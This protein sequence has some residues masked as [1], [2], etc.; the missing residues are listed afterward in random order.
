MT[1][2]VSMTAPGPG[3][4]PRRATPV[5]G[6]LAR[7]DLAS[8]I[9]ALQ[10]DGRRVIG[11]T[12]ADGAVV[13]DEIDDV[14]DLPIGW[15]VR[16]APGSYR[17]EQ[18]DDER[19]FD[20]VLGPTAWK[21]YTFPSVVPISVA[22][23]TGEDGHGVEFQRATETPPRLAFLGVRACEIAA[24]LVQ[25]RVFLGGPATDEDYRARRAAACIVAV[26]CTTSADTCFCTSMGT[27]PEVTG[28]FDLALTELADGFVV[29][30]GSDLGAAIAAGLPLV[31]ADAERV[32]SAADA[33][34]TVRASIGRPVAADGLPARLLAALDS[35]RWATV[36]ER[37]L[38][39]ANCTL[40]C[41]TCFCTSVGQVSDLDGLVSTSERRWDSCFNPG[42]A[43]VAGGNF[44]PR[45]RDR[46]RQWLTHKFATWTEQF[47][48]SGCVGCGRCITWCPVGIDVRAELLA[49]A[50]PTADPSAAKAN[51][52]PQ[53][54]PVATPIAVATAAP[55]ATRHAPPVAT[56][57]PTV[58]DA[59]PDTIRQAYL[60]ATV[61]AVHRETIDT[62]TLHLG[63]DDPRLLAGATGPVRHGRRCRPSRR[64][65]SRSRASGPTGST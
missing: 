25:D 42:F 20:Y 10:A 35:P 39:C 8:L 55:V 59:V 37:C 33:V 27:G 58:A 14:A 45:V 63:T 11:P 13:Y 18:R 64:R 23:R 30:V 49:I 9:R 17:L 32:R 52:T 26:E 7:A 62:V 43:Q 24:L 19:A 31:A 22:R 15:H 36:A 50:P 65:P 4:A 21:R 34:A 41:P 38:S 12:V 53:V 44:R 2:P 40:V 16:Q 6:F 46:Y 57:A 29:R 5:A 3:P 60:P 56:I 48:T 1:E 54:V 28:E 61:L 51:G 47:G